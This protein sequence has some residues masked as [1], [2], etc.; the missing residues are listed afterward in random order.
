[1]DSWDS[2]GKHV[3][4][5][6]EKIN[7][8]QEKFSSQLVDLDKGF[9]N[10]I[11]KIEIDIINKIN[12]LE[13]QNALLRMKSSLWGFSAGSLPSVAGAILDSLQGKM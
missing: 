13:T 1:M 3:I 9:T 7:K 8:T 12:K 4:K 6:L 2:W 5:E 10:Q 11:Q